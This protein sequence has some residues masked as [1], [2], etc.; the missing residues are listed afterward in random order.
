VRL[1]E[2]WERNLRETQPS[3]ATWSEELKVLLD[4][5]IE[6]RPLQLPGVGQVNIKNT[7]YAY[8]WARLKRGNTPDT[9]RY[10]QLKA[11]GYTNATTD[12]VDPMVNSVNASADGQEITCGIDLILMKALK[13]VHY[14]ALKFHHERALQMTNPRSDVA[15]DRI[16]RSGNFGDDAVLAATNSQNL[17]ESEVHSRIAKRGAK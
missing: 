13:K 7:E 5:S 2:S 10:M 3:R 8:Y 15:K 9:T 1:P 12:D 4:S 17:S 16:M 6:A 11:A 14:G